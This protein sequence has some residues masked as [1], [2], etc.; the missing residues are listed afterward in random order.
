MERLRPERDAAHQVRRLVIGRLVAVAAVTAL[1]RLCLDLE[2]FL[3]ERP[4]GHDR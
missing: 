2:R 1:D 3:L 4:V